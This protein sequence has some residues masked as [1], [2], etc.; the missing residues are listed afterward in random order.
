MACQDKD[1]AENFLK[2]GQTKGKLVAMHAMKAYWRVEGYMTSRH[3]GFVG[4]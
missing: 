3:R 2:L 1:K 4:V